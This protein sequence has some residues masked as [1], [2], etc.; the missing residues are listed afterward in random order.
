MHATGWDDVARQVGLQP[1]DLDVLRRL[2]I[3]QR[4]HPAT[5][6]RALRGARVI[7][8]ERGH[9]LFHRGD[10]ADR[11]FAVL[12]GWV[13][14]TRTTP[15]GQESVIGV[16]ARGQ[17]FAEAAIFLGGR[18]PVSG[19]TVE[20]TRLL[21]IPAAEFLARLKEEPDTLLNMLAAM[22][23]HLHDL[24]RQ[25]E[26]LSTR[27]SLERVAGFLASLGHGSD[28]PLHIRLP[29]DKALIAGRL[30][31][32]PET[33]SR[34]LMRLREHGVDEVDGVIRI[35]DPNALLRLSVGG[36]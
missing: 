2:V 3:F 20:R 8:F 33:F 21:V 12:E 22:S 34:A 19:S 4:I 31:M 32:R 25:V 35:E 26:Q 10:P 1:A 24:V 13:K 11:L 30:G 28:D 5:L 14:L 16:F 15:D 29:H 9:T 17:S 27:T 7:A 6:V 23:L 18:Y 36:A